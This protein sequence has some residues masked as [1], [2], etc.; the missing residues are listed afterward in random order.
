MFWD[1]NRLWLGSA[2]LKCENSVPKFERESHSSH[3]GS[4]IDPKLCKP[5]SYVHQKSHIPGHLLRRPPLVHLIIHMTQIPYIRCIYGISGRE[6]T[7]YTV[8][9]GAYIRFWP[10]LHISIVYTWF[11][12]TLHKWLHGSYKCI[13]KDSYKCIYLYI[14]R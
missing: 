12:P 4:P 1:E 10:T 14:Q 9:Y 6:V 11:W 7:R 8:I 2:G 13:Y 5:S 3:W